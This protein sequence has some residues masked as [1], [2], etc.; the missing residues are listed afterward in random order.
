M[1]QLDEALQPF[2]GPGDHDGEQSMRIKHLPAVGPLAYLH[3]IYKPVDSTIVLAALERVVGTSLLGD[4]Y[5]LQ[6][7]AELFSGSIR[8][9]GCVA[10]GTRLDRSRPF[11]L[12]PLDLVEI[13]Q[14]YLSST[15]RSRVIRIAS[16]SVDRSIVCIERDSAEVV[17][18]RG[19]GFETERRRW[20]SMEAWLLEEIERLSWL[21]SPAGQLLVDEEATL[22]A[23]SQ[24]RVF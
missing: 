22:P 23:T 19:D 11:S 18:F 14:Q 24:P 9:Y 17:C 15:E 7:G 2:M 10:P 13:N 1:I 12:P 3:V 4:F 16:Y 20:A 6:N 8:I 5:M 21:F